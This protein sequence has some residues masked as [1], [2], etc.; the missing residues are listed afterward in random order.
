MARTPFASPLR[1][2][3]SWDPFHEF[4][5]W[6][7]TNNTDWCI[8]AS[9][10]YQI[11]LYDTNYCPGDGPISE[12]FCSDFTQAYV[13]KCVKN[14]ATA[15]DDKSMVAV[16]A[17]ALSCALFSG[18]VASM[19][20]NVLPE[21][22]VCIL[23]G[24]GAGSLLYSTATKENH[25]IE[26]IGFDASIFFLVLVPPIA[27]QSLLEVN[28]KHFC[29]NFPSIMWL[30]ICNTILTCLTVGFIVFYCSDL[31][32]PT[33]LLMGAISSSVD[34]TALRV[35]LDERLQVLSSTSTTKND[36]D[37]DQDQDPNSRRNKASTTRLT[38]RLNDLDATI[39]GESTLNDGVSFVL[40]TA[41][42]P[43][44]IGTSDVVPTPSESP[45][46][47]I[48]IASSRSL[49]PSSTQKLEQTAAECIA[50]FIT[51]YTASF[52]VGVVSGLIAAVI[53]K[54]FSN[55]CA[56]RA[57]DSSSEKSAGRRGMVV[58]IALLLLPYF[59]CELVD[60][61]GLVGLSGK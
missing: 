1:G 14:D 49:T 37:Q 45:M 42:L 5:A 44:V 59:L 27:L 58:F 21:S 52:S 60:L 13:T 56:L 41:L 18:Y 3:P 19:K 50:N 12:T 30:A 16:F 46:V 7:T 53:F 34:P 20:C 22:A 33:C 48:D 11:M 29:R 31:S 15:T 54:L 36:Q 47:T 6:L 8:T 17:V 4:F 55:S 39:F 25:N 40:Y 10:Y 26:A 24:L 32:M 35:A 38:T 51:I 2:S 28:P 9:N 43:L 57:I 61:S 23:V